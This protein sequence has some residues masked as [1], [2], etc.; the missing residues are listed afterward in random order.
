[1]DLHGVP[2]GLSEVLLRPQRCVYTHFFVLQPTASMVVPHE[3][4]VVKRLPPSLQ[5]LL[6]D[7]RDNSQAPVHA[8]RPAAP[9]PLGLS[10][11]AALNATGAGRREPNNAL[12]AARETAA[13]DMHRR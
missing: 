13:P 7:H 2:Q 6:E 9:S 5:R 4:K 12:Q 11:S 1:M 3:K 10:Q 8:T